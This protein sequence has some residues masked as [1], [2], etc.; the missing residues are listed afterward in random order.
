MPL[1]VG[2]CGTLRE[3][4][5]LP[6]CKDGDVFR[7][8]GSDFTD[9]DETL[10]RDG[11]PGA[12]LVIDDLGT[13][14]H[15][16]VPEDA[17]TVPSRRAPN[18]NHLGG[19]FATPSTVDVRDLTNGMVSTQIQLDPDVPDAAEYVR[20]TAYRLDPTMNV[21]A[22]RSVAFNDEYE[23]IRRGLF[24]A[25]ALTMTLIA[26]SLLVSQIEQLRDR[27]R[28]L[29]ILVAYGTRRS[30]LAWSVLWQTAIPV[31][32]GMV[33]AVG[34]GLALGTLMLR[35]V[36]DP[37]T[38]WLAFLPLAGV[39]LAAIAAVTLLSLPPLYRLMRPEGLR[40]E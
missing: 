35:M 31:A 4:A 13:K 26:A 11:K 25:A 32:L 1:T 36:G 14:A 27:R 3:L 20:N 7:V 15:W 5:K 8:T 21:S 10:A 24:S 2:S 17:R 37:V 6:S 30:T 29:S 22:F 33:V 18:G 38:D 12:R 23:A 28:L 40:T 19:I 16:T 9:D 34:G 39:G